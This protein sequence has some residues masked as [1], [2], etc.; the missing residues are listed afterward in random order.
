MAEGREKYIAGI[1]GMVLCVC[2]CVYVCVCV[3]VCVCLA[4]AGGFFTTDAPWEAQ[5]FCKYIYICKIFAWIPS[6]DQEDPLEEGMA[7]HSS[8][9]S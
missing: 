6:L 8:F 9:L 5:I 1:S 3:C 2:V 7:T 4:L